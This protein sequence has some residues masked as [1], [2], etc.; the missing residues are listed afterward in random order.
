MYTSKLL[1]LS[2]FYGLPLLSFHGIRRHENSYAQDPVAYYK[3]NDMAIVKIPKMGAKIKVR[4]FAGMDENSH[5]A[6]QRYKTWAPEKNIVAYLSGAYMDRCTGNAIPL[7]LCIESGRVINRAIRTDL[8][9][10]VIISR[11][12][13]INV[14]DL[15]QGSVSASTGGTSRS[16]DIMHSS[17]QLNQFIQWCEVEKITLYQT[18]LLIQNDELMLSRSNSSSTLAHRRLVAVCRDYNGGV[19]HYLFNIG[20]NKTLYD[21]ADA[22]YAFL[23][24]R[25]AS[26]QYLFNS[27]TGC[28][29]VFCVYTA[30][31]EKISD[32][33]F[34]GDINLNQASNLL[35][36][37]SD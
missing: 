4:Y 18:H 2:V 37:Y 1:L 31:G 33:Q 5:G 29:N 20:S 34:E 6:P 8:Q 35:V 15:R 24:N 23:H 17:I 21:A 27:D 25:V 28:Q 11:D 16:F 19:T 9:G 26:I 32:S 3:T 14:C 10:L 22:A 12:G 13:L 7:G 36:Y 30:G